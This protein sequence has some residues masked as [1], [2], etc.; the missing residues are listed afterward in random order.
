[1]ALR[2]KFQ[3]FRSKALKDLGLVSL[4]PRWRVLLPVHPT[5]WTK[6]SDGT[7]SSIHVLR[8]VGLGNFEALFLP[9]VDNPFPH[10]FKRGLNVTLTI[11]D[12]LMFRITSTPLL[13][14]YVSGSFVWGLS[15][16]VR[17]DCPRAAPGAGAVSW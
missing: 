16:V 14:E 7:F 11:D 4:D 8:S 10:F 9:Y 12:P 2:A 15:M 3:Q 6:R 1:L 5:S 17:G 13:E